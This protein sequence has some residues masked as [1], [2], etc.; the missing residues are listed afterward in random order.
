MESI[1]IHEWL[2]LIFRWVHV[3]VG[4]MWIGQTYLFNWLETRFREPANASEKK[5]VAGQVWMVHG[6]GFYLVE[7]QTVPE[8]MP[9]KLYWFK[10]ESAFTWISGFLLLI[11]VYYMGGLVLLP[12]SELSEMAGVGIGLGTLVGGW[13]VY[14]LLCRT[15][16][17]NNDSLFAVVSYVLIVVLIYLLGQVLSDRA[18][19]I[20]IGAMF[21]TIM[22]AN[23]WMRIMPAQRQMVAATTAGT[24]V[25]KRLASRAKQCSKHNTFLSVPLIFLM[26]S[27]HFPTATYG[28]EHGWIVLSILI[29]VGW[30]AAKLIRD[31]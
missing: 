7:K 10:W 19:Y 26:I 11:V 24:E 1:N 5:N 15:P 6:G 28:N 25:D 27:N 29:L 3:I 22:A 14:A 13:V 4:I 21:G 9:R 20:H 23:V 30:G 12:D 18:T 16:L 17:L 8:M 2:N 31:H